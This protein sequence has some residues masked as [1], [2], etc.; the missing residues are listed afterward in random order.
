MKILVTG[1]S[2]YIGSH[3][4]KAA[5]THE[6]DVHG[7]LRADSDVRLLEMNQVV[8]DVCL[9]RFDGCFENLLSILREV[10]PEV[11]VH[12]ATLYAAEH[13]F[14]KIGPLVDSNVKFGVELLEAMRQASIPGIVVAETA[15]QYNEDGLVGPSNLYAATKE[16]FS[17]ILRYYS[18]AYGLKVVKM[19]LFDTY[20]GCDVRPKLLNKI[21]EVLK[22]GGVLELSEG[23]QILDFTHVEDVVDAFC[24]AVGRLQAIRPGTVEEYKVS[25]HRM[26]LKDWIE[27]LNELLKTALPT[28]LGARPYRFREVMCPW[29]GGRA[30]EGWCPRI[31]PEVGMVEFFLNG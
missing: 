25:G 17:V 6:W 2:G 12:F 4:A 9:H 24:L 20:G 29:A 26:R 5:S 16:A 15:W 27:F 30:I 19:K 22:N 18:D 7:L 21:R 28:K 1:I 23:G 11:V 14:S 8:E 13:D 10:Q 31:P 3:F